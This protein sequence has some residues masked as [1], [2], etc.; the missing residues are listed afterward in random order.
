M[1]K[2]QKDV[3]RDENFHTFRMV[4]RNNVWNVILNWYFFRR[5]ILKKLC[6]VSTQ[7][8]H[9]PKVLTNAVPRRSPRAPKK[10][11][12]PSQPLGAKSRL[13]HASLTIALQ[14]LGELS[15]LG[16]KKPQFH[17]INDLHPLP[18][19]RQNAPCPLLPSPI[20]SKYVRSWRL[21]A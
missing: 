2:K 15:H 17:R 18:P 21:R 6:Q 1:R 16:Q 3:H 5:E 20:T 9:T 8:E 19:T 4:L 12:T 14:I 13:S 11:T 10:K 7:M